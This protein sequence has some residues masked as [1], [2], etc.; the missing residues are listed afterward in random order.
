MKFA[1]FYLFTLT[2]CAIFWQCSDLIPV[3][4]RSGAGPAVLI[5]LWLP[6]A[7]LAL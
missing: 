4:S 2:G 1:A 7:V 3:L 6:T 5:V